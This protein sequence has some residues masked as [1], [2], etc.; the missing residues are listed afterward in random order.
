MKIETLMWLLPAVFMLH[1]FEEIIMVQP[2]VR[3]NAPLLQKRFPKLAARFLPHLQKLSTPAFALAVAEEFILLTLLTC[4]AVEFNLYALWAGIVLGF[5][6]HLLV[7]VI[8]F[9]VYRS[10]IPAILT[11]VPAGLYCLAALY[12][13]DARVNLIWPEVAAWTLAALVVIAVNLMMA[14]GLA[15]RFQRYLDEHSA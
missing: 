8:Q 9:G 15:A 4:L 14:H 3:R 11:S 6:I 10:Y 13:L 7:H 1:D 5:F 12:S 2:W